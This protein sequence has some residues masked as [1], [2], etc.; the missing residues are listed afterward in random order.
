MGRGSHKIFFSWPFIFLLQLSS[1]QLGVGLSAETLGAL[2][3]R[4]ES[5]VNDQL[6]QDTQ[7]TGHTEQNGIVVGL[8]QT[9]VL[10]EDTRVLYIKISIYYLF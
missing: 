8:G 7:S 3:G 9:V 1:N 2:N 5:T 4:T 6:G 10:E